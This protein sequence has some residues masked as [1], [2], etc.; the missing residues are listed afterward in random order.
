MPALAIQAEELLIINS[1]AEPLLYGSLGSDESSIDINVSESLFIN[2]AAES[3][4]YG[5]LGSDAPSLDVE[6]N[7]SLLVDSEGD[8]LFYEDLITPVSQW[9]DK[10][11]NARHVS[12]PTAELQPIYQPNG[13]NQQPTV[14][15]DGTDDNLYRTDA[16]VYQTGG[17]CV[18]MVAKSSPLANS[19]HLFAEASTA[20]TNPLYGVS[21]AGTVGSTKS[22]YFI[23]N[24]ANVT[25]ATLPSSSNAPFNDSPHMIGFLDNGSTLII[26]TDGTD[27]SPVACVRSGT[28]TLDRFAVGGIM[29]STPANRFNGEISEIIIG[30][31]DLSLAARRQLEGYLAHRWQLDSLL[32]IDHPYKSAPPQ[33]VLSNATLVSCSA[34]YQATGRQLIGK[35]ALVSAATMVAVTSRKIGTRGVAI[36]L[37]SS[38]HAAGRKFVARGVATNVWHGAVTRASPSS[39]ARASGNS[40][41]QTTGRK[42]SGHAA[43]I[44]LID[45]IA[46]RSGPVLSAIGSVSASALA[47]GRKSV[48]HAA[49]ISTSAIALAR[50][51][52]SSDLSVVVSASVHAVGGK[53]IAR[54]AATTL[55]SS[56]LTSARKLA[57]R[58]VIISAGSSAIASGVYGASLSHQ[59]KY[60]SVASITDCWP[61]DG[62]PCG[63]HRSWPECRI[64]RIDRSYGCSAASS[65][66]PPL[67]SRRPRR[68][69]KGA[70]LPLAAWVRR[71]ALNVVLA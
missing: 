57:G 17:A 20:S 63:D 52:P 4:I 41:C 9:N 67:P 29:R 2:S 12:Q 28:L 19:R 3:L 32:P 39:A 50:G 33:A 35:A 21:T 43:T 66:L 23:R 18:Y 26:S 40:A 71:P 15:F 24:D 31:G 6:T 1:A 68:S 42:A 38:I 69:A 25:V 14:S 59:A 56:S 49:N 51:G 8:P 11:G 36:T 27:D 22:R 65:R 70:S 62:Q 58:Q 5:N 45:S 44:A 47:V 53:R 7:E 37:A 55:A 64:L 10:S 13:F 34:S 54:S 30:N 46:V 16:F 48:G 60:V 61:Q